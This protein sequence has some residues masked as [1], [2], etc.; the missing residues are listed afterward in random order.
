[1]NSKMDKWKCDWVKYRLHFNFEARTSRQVM[2]YKDTYFVRIQDLETGEFGV[3]EA[4]LFPGL[5]A[6]DT[7][8]FEERLTRACLSQRPWDTHE[9]NSSAITFGLDS[10]LRMLL[11]KN[12]K[13]R[14]KEVD[15]LNDWLKGKA[16]IP[17]NGLVWMGDRATMAQRIKEKLNQGFHCL[18]LKIG[19]INFD[20]EVALLDVI[21]CQ[22]SHDEL[23]IR[24]DANGAF[25]PSEAMEKLEELSHYKI[26]SI[27]QPIKPGQ[28]KEM[29]N[30]C[31]NS[32]I[33]IALDE[34]LIG[35]TSLDHKFELTQFIRPQYLVLKPALCG[36]FRDTL[37]WIQIGAKAGAEWW[38]TSALESN[39]GLAAIA[40][41]VSTLCPDIPQGLGTGQLYTNNIPS[42]LFMEGECL[43]YNPEKKFDYGVIGFPG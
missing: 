36:G 6:D 37:D 30:L 27:E 41:W 2:T 20:D 26:H 5:S 8:D 16:G 42:P 43:W 23:E 18:K 24:L 10:A 1:M 29:R 39:V 25:S 19:G 15:E 34:E 21:R 9:Y 31:R 17:I 32:P 35:V 13:D 40:R 22:F 3:G 4:N 38:V 33:P 11:E 28:W 14:F 12:H 7:P